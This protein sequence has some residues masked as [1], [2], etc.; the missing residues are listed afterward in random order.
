MAEENFG[1]WSPY[2][3]EA[4][5][6][7]P[8]ATALETPNETDAAEQRE[9]EA[10]TRPEKGEREH[11]NRGRAG[12]QREARVRTTASDELPEIDAAGNVIEEI[13]GGEELP[14]TDEP[15]A[16]AFSAKDLVSALQEAGVVVPSQR[17]QTNDRVQLTPEQFAKKYNVY[18]PT[19]ETLASLAA[20]GDR[21]IAAID[22]IAQG[23]SLQTVTMMQEYVNNK[24]ESVLGQIKPFQEAQARQ[25]EEGYKTRFYAKH[26]DLKPYD[27]IL[28]MQ[29]ADAKQRNLKFKDE[30]AMFDYFNKSAR[31]LL[32]TLN[33]VPQTV[34]RGQ[35]SVQPTTVRRRIAPVTTGGS[36]T[37]DS[38]GRTVQQNGRGSR[39]AKQLWG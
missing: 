29:V 32:K 11:L 24:I 20:G 4:Q 10:L 3:D 18:T 30:A 31:G 14:P 1:D 26:P 13:P 5:T 38:D 25:Q 7:A 37:G 8:G 34:V 35:S 36:P 33:V 16:P 9:R 27:R 19:A 39:I 2:G 23:A 21:A 28:Q 6:G 15:A 22:E 12:Q 17:Q